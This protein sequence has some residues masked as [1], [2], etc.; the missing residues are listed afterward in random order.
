[1]RRRLWGYLL[2]LS[3]FLEPYWCLPLGRSSSVFASYWRFVIAVY[4]GTSNSLNDLCVLKVSISL[5]IWSRP[6]DRGTCEANTKNSIILS[7]IQVLKNLPVVINHVKV[8]ILYYRHCGKILWIPIE[9]NHEVTWAIEQDKCNH[10]HIVS[11]K[12]EENYAHCTINLFV[13]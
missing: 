8:L 9:A 7:Y 4:Q 5:S 10:R 3:W 2:W 11:N 12:L 6:T 13:K 1:M